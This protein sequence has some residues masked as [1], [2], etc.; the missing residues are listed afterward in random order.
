M[1]DKEKAFQTARK[2]IKEIG[3]VIREEIDQP[4]N[5]DTKT[6]PND[7]VTEM[8]RKV[9]RFFAL[10]IRNAYP[11]DKILSEEGFGDHVTSLEGT[12]WIIDPIDGTMNF[13]H[14]KRNFAISLAIY[15]EKQGEIGFVYDV[16]ADVLYAAK[17]GEGAYKNDQRLATLDDEKKF[18][19]SIYMLN[20][21]WTTDNAIVDA[22]KIRALVKDVR[23]VRTYGSAALEFCYLAE[24]IV[25]GYV[26]FKLHP[27]DVAAG[28]VIY[29][30]VGGVVKHADGSE[31]S[32]LKQEPL[33]AGHKEIV[34]ETLKHY[35]VLN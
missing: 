9:E 26:S 11:N 17:R 18:T 22:E 14:Q 31:L 10:K 30:E 15:H 32:Y 3:H 35:L 16:M 1:F 29:K 34:A 21:I 28:A 33:V 19:E 8:D 24:G 4:R 20:T 5:V 12:T 25:D 2:W 13:I 7:L 6:N 23:G 27:W